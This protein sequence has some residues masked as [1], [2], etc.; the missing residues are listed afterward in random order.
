MFNSKKE[1]DIF[2]NEVNIALQTLAE[3]YNFNIKCGHI[4]YSDI[5]FKMTVEVKDKEIDGKSYEQANFE[6][7]CL[8]YG[9]KPNDYH[10]QFSF[11]GNTY[12]LCGFNPKARKMPVLAANCNGQKFKFEASSVKKL[13][14]KMS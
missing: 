14:E 5:D 4:S 6:K 12:T 8:C 13:I 3:K 11:N 2:R 7:L 9:F 10:K 1:F